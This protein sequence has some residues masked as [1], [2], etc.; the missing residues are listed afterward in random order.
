MNIQAVEMLESWMGNEHTV[1]CWFDWGGKRYAA[2]YQNPPSCSVAREL[3][4]ERAEWTTEA[5]EEMKANGGKWADDWRTKWEGKEFFAVLEPLPAGSARR[6]A[7]PVMLTWPEK[8]QGG[9]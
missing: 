7:R 8:K 3:L 1:L 2:Y 6:W 4:M 9:V 5:L